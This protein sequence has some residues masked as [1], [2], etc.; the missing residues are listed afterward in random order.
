VRLKLLGDLKSTLA[1]RLFQ[2][3]TTHSLKKMDLTRIVQLF[4]YNLKLWPVVLW[5][6]VHSKS[7]LLVYQLTQTTFYNNRWGLY[8]GAA[9]PIYVDLHVSDD[10]DMT[11]CLN[12]LSKATL[13]RFNCLNVM[14]S[15]RGP[16]MYMW[17]VF[18]TALTSASL[19]LSTL[20]SASFSLRKSIKCQMWSAVKNKKCTTAKD[21]MSSTTIFLVQ[22]V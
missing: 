15:K 17:T 22:Q 19:H 12:Q 3:L 20:I 11:S 13:N 6:G 8:R 14:D 18:N 4:L 10:R 2:T 16:N 1:S 5:L 9:V 21:L 7:R